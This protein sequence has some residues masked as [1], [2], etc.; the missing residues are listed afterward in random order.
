MAERG[1][2]RTDN[3]RNR[4]LS[5]RLTESEYKEID[6]KAK[7]TGMAKTDLVLAGIRLMASDNK[8]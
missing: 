8:K 7:E 2:P 5:I 1:R 4:R 3:P 6:D